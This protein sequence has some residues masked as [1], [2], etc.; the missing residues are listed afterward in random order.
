MRKPI[1]PPTWFVAGLCA[2]LV[3]DLV[4][5][6]V[7]VLRLPWT[8]VGIIPAAAGAAL[9]LAA[10]RAFKR[11]NTTVRPFEESSALVTGGVFGLSRNPMY[12]GMVPIQ[13]GFALL[14]GAATPFL[15]CAAFAVLLHDQVQAS[16]RA[17]RSNLPH[18][19]IRTPDG[20]CFASPTRN[21]LPLPLREGLGGRRSCRFDPSPQPP[22]TRGGGSL[23]RR[24]GACC[25]IQGGSA[26][27]R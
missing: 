11:H 18:A 17:R 23:L 19:L 12:L 2:M 4:F 1:L 25:F 24:G 22:P 5:P 26:G 27:C 14:L 8:L 16:L 21:R 10:D 9:N 6:A 3:L 15:I 13:L 20:D 7:Q